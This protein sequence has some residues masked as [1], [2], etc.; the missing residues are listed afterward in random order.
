MNCFVNASA[1]GAYKSI[2]ERANAFQQTSISSVE[3][4]PKCITASVSQHLAEGM[5]ID[6]L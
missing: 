6:Y 4:N 1:R 2:H 3:A 5:Y